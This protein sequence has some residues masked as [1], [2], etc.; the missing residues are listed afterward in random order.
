MGF[1]EMEVWGR[2]EDG[3]GDGGVVVGLWRG[4]GGGDFLK[5]KRQVH[6][7]IPGFQ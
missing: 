5:R 3:G 6:C 4:Y 7:Y 2:G 1:D